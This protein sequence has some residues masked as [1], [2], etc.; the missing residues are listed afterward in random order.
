MLRRFYLSLALTILVCTYSCAQSY[1]VQISVQL[2]PPFSGYLPDY[3]SPGNDNLRIYITFMDFSQ[4]TY[5]VKLKFALTGNN[6]SIQ[7]RS[8]Y[9]DGPVTLEPG[10]PLMLTGTDLSGMLSS[11]NLDYSGITLAQ[12]NQSKVLPEGFYTINVTAYDFANPLPIQVSNVGT[13]QAWMLLCDPPLTNLP[14]CGSEVITSDP[15]FVA[16]SWSPLNMTAPTS[17]LGTEYLFELWEVMP[18]NNNPNNV[19]LVTAPMYTITTNLTMITYGIAEPPL[20]V[21]WTYVWRVRAYDLDNRALFRNNGYSQICTFTYGD[22]SELLGNL[23]QLTLSATVLTHRQ[24]RCNWDSTS[25]Y[26]SYH[27]EFRKINTANW[28]PHNTTSASLR[29]TSLEPVTQ[30][31][32]QVQGIF[33]NGEEGPWSNIVTFTTP[34]QAVLNCGE[35]SPPPSQQNFSPLTQATTGMIWQVGQFEMIVTQLNNMSNANGLYSG[36]GKVIMPL[37]VTVNCS[38]TNVQIG[39]DQ[40]MYAGQVRGITEGVSNWLSQWN[41]GFDYDTSYFFNAGIDSIY[42]SN[43]VIIIIDENGN[44]TTVP[45]DPNG[46]VLITDSNGNQWI[47][48]SDGTVVP[49]SGG[50]LLPLTNDTLN[51]QEMRIMKSAM[52]II[53]NQLTPQVVSGQQ[54]TMNTIE[55]Q[56]QNRS[57]QQQQQAVGGNVPAPPTQVDDQYERVTF[58]QRDANPNDP[59]DV[60]GNQYKSAQLDYYCSKVLLI[61]SRED[62]PDQELDL[63]GQYLTINGILFKSYVTQQLAAGKTEAEIAALVAENGIKQLVRM[64]LIKQMSPD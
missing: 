34:A 22:E 57:D 48:Q 60:L 40:V 52:T 44:Q 47:V 16:F 8:W 15:Q 13:T 30:Y 28:F 19:V 53:R 29:L 46:G 25:V 20:Q 3:A 24:A 1:P 37:G 4:P 27:L 11:A 18:P 7:S 9:Y 2:V 5:D 33:P 50:Y 43:G 10:V 63:V 58:I 12:Y 61:M 21:G 49:V 36:L 14:A 38:Y 62:C 23:A 39:V 64:T 56:L 6:V 26:A 54:S 41:F 31:E 32:A 35:A 17:A 45:I 55:T 59:G 42:V 51:D